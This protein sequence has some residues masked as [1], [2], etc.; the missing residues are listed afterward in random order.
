MRKHWFASAL[1]RATDLSVRLG[2]E[3]RLVLS[4]LAP[5]SYAAVAACILIATHVHWHWLL[6][7]TLELTLLRVSGRLMSGCGWWLPA[8]F[9]CVAV[10]AFGVVRRVCQGRPG[11]LRWFAAALAFSPPMTMAWACTGFDF[12]FL[13]ADLLL[14]CCIS[15]LAS[16]AWL[17][18]PRPTIQ[19]WA[20]YAPGTRV[21]L[22][23]FEA[24]KYWRGL[25]ILWAA[26]A[27]GIAALGTYV[28]SGPPAV[29]VEILSTEQLH[30]LTDARVWIALALLA[31]FLPGII[32]I[33]GAVVLRVNR[34]QSAMEEVEL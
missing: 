34:I 7:R 15:L 17:P 31:T 21:N 11:P 16:L 30:A 4:S 28:I 29:W 18:D 25:N 12:E 32:W 33:V 8:L 27:A 5:E 14:G 13:F 19:R 24:D 6:S 22:L 23:R 2:Q 26:T 3:G 10:V 20:Q 9:S 1:S